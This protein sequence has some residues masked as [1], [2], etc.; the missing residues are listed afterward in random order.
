MAKKVVVLLVVL[1]FCLILLAACGQ[2]GVENKKIGDINIEII[3]P[4]SLVDNLQSWYKDAYKEKFSHSVSYIDGYKYVLICAGEMP[5]AGYEI[6]LIDAKKENGAIVFYAKLIVP[7]QDKITTDVITYPHILFRVKE[8]DEVSIRAELDM[9]GIVS[10]QSISDNYV[11]LRGIYIGLADSNSV[12]IDIDPSFEFPGNGSSVVFKLTDSVIAYFN[13]DNS[14][15]KE[16]KNNELVEFDCL[17][18]AEGLWEITKITK[19]TDSL[20]EESINGEYVGQADANSVEI[21]IEG[22]PETFRLSDH[23]KY[24]IE[25]N[26]IETGTKVMV[27][28]IQE[29]GVRTITNIET[30][31]N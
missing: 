25:L 27:R 5:T 10:N 1:I 8:K 23:V 24:D 18:T 13:K 21:N 9:S 6:D 26:E 28:F 4:D 11:G 29:A 30:A 12:E 19:I 22:I 7:E 2:K 3:E 14:E 16:F 20:Q 15:Y 31:I 17:R